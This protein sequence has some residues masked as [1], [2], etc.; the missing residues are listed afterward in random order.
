MVFTV[1]PTFCVVTGASKGIGR[2]IVLSLADRLKVGSHLVLLARN[3][4][5]LQNVKSEVLEKRSNDLDVSVV[6]SDLSKPIF[7]VFS[8]WLKSAGA[9]S[10]F[11]SA[12]LVQN[13]ATDCDVSK[14]AKGKVH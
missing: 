13:A 1:G 4:E 6:I 8:D 9:S 5:L 12:L 11:S 14:R 2:A 7:S 3:Q 10:V